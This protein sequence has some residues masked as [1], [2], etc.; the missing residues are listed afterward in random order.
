[1]DNTAGFIKY[2]DNLLEDIL[3]S[4]NIYTTIIASAIVTLVIYSILTEQSPDIHPFHLAVQASTSAVRLPGESAKYRALETPQ[5]YPL[6]SGFNVKDPSSPKWSRGRNGDLRDIWAQFVHS[7]FP[8]VEQIG[9]VKGKIS[10]VLGKDALMEHDSD[11]LSQE[12]NII[13]HFIQ[14]HQGSRVAIYLPNSIEFLLTLF[15]CAFFNFTPILI[16]FDQSPDTLLNILQRTKPD[17]LVS[18][19]G[20]FPLSTII[21]G[22]PALSQIIWVVAMGSR[23]LDWSEVPEGIG[24][25]VGVSVWHDIIEDQK[26]IIGNDLVINTYESLSNVVTIWQPENG[27]VGE[28]FEFTQANLISAAAAQMSSVPSIER[29][30]STDIFAPLDSL[31]STY[32]LVLT[33]TALFSNASLVL[34]SVSGPKVDIP[35]ATRSISPTVIVASSLS[36][37]NML[38]DTVK[39][40]DKGIHSFVHRMHKRTLSQGRMPGSNSITQFFDRV[41]PVIG[42]KP[43]KLRLLFISQSPNL[44]SQLLLSEELDDLRI[45]TKAKVAYALTAKGVAGAVTQT[46]VFDYRPSTSPNSPAHFGSPLGC[47]EIKLVNAHGFESGFPQGEIHVSGPAV[48]GGATNTDLIGKFQEDH[49]LTCSV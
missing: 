19:A 18:S 34:N 46:N 1:M 7:T 33:L 44:S 15:A 13:G 17:I 23:H 30:I 40:L 6:V 31:T 35:L 9:G 45:F 8:N 39:K 16:P 2:L 41:M 38:K 47:I 14:S 4:W 10:T 20:S 26:A 12:M 32:T 25:S 21:K 29:I 22:Y 24:G 28:I 3:G 27:Q 42:C 37:S 43:G 48:I 36:A 5:G 49:T 11:E